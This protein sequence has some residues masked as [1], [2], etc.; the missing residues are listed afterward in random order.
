MI[1]LITLIYTFLSLAICTKK[2]HRPHQSP[3]ADDAP[4]Y[5]VTAI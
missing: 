3:D 4:F 2:K 1:V 5:F